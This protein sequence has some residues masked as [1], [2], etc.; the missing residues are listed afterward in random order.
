MII[1]MSSIAYAF[2]YVDL[3]RSHWSL[4]YYGSKNEDNKSMWTGSCPPSKSSHWSIPHF[5]DTHRGYTQTSET[6]IY[7]FF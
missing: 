4:G 6:Q 5:N 3:N 1:V 2:S 7:V